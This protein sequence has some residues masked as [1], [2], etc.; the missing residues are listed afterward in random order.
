MFSTRQT[1]TDLDAILV[2]TMAQDV[3]GTADIDGRPISTDLYNL[4][5]FV[6]FFLV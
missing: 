2:L 4:Q 5:L 3:N 1:G 6:Y